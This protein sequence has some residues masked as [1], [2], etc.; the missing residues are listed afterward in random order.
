M[1]AN[2]SV[3]LSRL[4]KGMRLL[5]WSTIAGKSRID[6]KHLKSSSVLV[7]LLDVGIRLTVLLLFLGEI[8]LGASRL[9]DRCAEWCVT[10]RSDVTSAANARRTA[11]LMKA[12]MVIVE[13]VF[14]YV[15]F[16]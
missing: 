12:P 6:V 16:R 14:E 7:L 4:R 9:T 2:H 5:S 15:W 11:G 10:V 1:F 3:V 8:S 13:S